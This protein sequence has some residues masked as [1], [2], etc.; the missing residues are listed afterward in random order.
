MGKTIKILSAIGVLLIAL[1][2]AAV[3]IIKSMDF[4]QYKG[5]IA[6][7]AKAATGRDLTITG[8]LNLS[9]SLTPRISVDGVT[10]SNASWGTKPE[11][12]SIKRFV[13]EM[14]L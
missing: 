13:A 8:D 5:E 7:Q 2:V 14:S 6:A 9:I 12:V 10:F 1:V 4:N 11:M 3:A